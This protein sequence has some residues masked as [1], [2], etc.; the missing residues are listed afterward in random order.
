MSA[1]APETDVLVPE[2]PEARPARIGLQV[3]TVVA[4]VMLAIVALVVIVVPF[5][6]GFAPDEQSYAVALR[7]PF[8]SADHLLGTDSL[9]RD[10]LD[11]ISVAARV[12]LLVAAGAV[13]ISGVLGTA[14]GLVAGYLRGRVETVLMGIADI[15]LSIPI[16]LVLIVVVATI[17]SSPVILVVFLGLTSWVGYARVVRSLVVSLREREYIT[18][19]VAAGASAFWIV[20]RHLIRAVLPHVFILAAFEVGLVITIESSLSYLGLGIQPPTPSL[21]LMISEGQKYMQT[22]PAL[23]IVPAVIIFLLIGGT[24][25]L[26]QNARRRR[27]Y[28]R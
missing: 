7:A 24:Q 1:I 19:G 16:L 6:P 15:Q 2:I 20:R 23:T 9:G 22:N 4:I 21:G 25:F 10:I 18:A 27:G 8:V 17:G 5:L 3:S 12:S 11:R 14:I 28:D 13:A 26:S